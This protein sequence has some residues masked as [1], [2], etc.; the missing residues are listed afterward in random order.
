MVGGD[1]SRLGD[2]AVSVV[3]GI[4]LDVSV[5]ALPDLDFGAVGVGRPEVRNVEIVALFLGVIL[6]KGWLTA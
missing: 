1:V 3:G 5:A 6:H 4:V 2:E